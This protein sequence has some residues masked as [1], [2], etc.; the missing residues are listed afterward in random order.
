MARMVDQESVARGG[1]QER[2]M[3][4]LWLDF[5][6]TAIISIVAIALAAWALRHRDRKPSSGQ[7]DQKDPNGRRSR[8]N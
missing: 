7:G 1:D 2:R 4:N 5:V 3:N 8:K 6:R